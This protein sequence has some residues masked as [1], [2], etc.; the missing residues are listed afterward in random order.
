MHLNAVR[1]LSKFM[2]GAC[3]ANMVAMKRVMKYCECT[4]NRGMQLKANR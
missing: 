2:S 4:P 3:E 1:E